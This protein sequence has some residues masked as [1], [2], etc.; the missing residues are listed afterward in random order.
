MKIL[1]VHVTT[2]KIA[3]TK[4]YMH[5]HG[6]ALSKRGNLDPWSAPVAT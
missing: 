2:A 3:E 6:P 4:I 1:I 5:L